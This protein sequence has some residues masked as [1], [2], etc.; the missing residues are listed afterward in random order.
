MNQ[1]VDNKT[2]KIDRTKFKAYEC[3]DI[4]MNSYNQQISLLWPFQRW[5]WYPQIFV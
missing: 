4:L 2:V 3:L 5:E 1:Q